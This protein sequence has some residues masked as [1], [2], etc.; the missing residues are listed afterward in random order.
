MC[1]CFIVTLVI[2]YDRLYFLK[3]L[4]VCVVSG[5]RDCVSDS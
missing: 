3:L 2:T 4:R 1:R 5:V